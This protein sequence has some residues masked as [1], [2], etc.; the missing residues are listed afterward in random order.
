MNEKYAII[1]FLIDNNKLLL[2]TIFKMNEKQIIHFL[3][4]IVKR[5]ILQKKTYHSYYGNDRNIFAQKVTCVVV[6]FVIGRA[7]NKIAIFK[8]I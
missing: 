4:N 8:I 7:V 3:C 2:K 5:K 6:V 1:T